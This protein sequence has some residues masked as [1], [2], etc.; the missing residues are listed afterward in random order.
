[1]TRLSPLTLALLVPYVLTES[2]PP[3]V[4]FQGNSSGPSNGLPPAG[5][6]SLQT[7]D[8][9]PN[10]SHTVSFNFP[11]D[12]QWDWRLQIS[13]AYIRGVSNDT[14][15]STVA[16]TTWHLSLP[17]NDSQSA[18]SSSA[19][20]CAYL[21]DADFPP[22]VSTEWDQDSA[23]CTPAIG[24]ACEK[25]ILDHTS[26]LDDCSSG[27]TSPL[28]YLDACEGSLGDGG[29][30]VQGLRRSTCIFSYNAVY[31]Y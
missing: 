29:F 20:T 22:N 5:Y 27:N 4:Q 14:S 19:P 3:Y 18:S 12:R 15:K 8:T 7:A 31:R 11:D 9:R 23:S 16:F 17:D 10:A 13:E 2:F 1:M 30:L 25:A 26:V 21:I 24:S 6:E 28:G